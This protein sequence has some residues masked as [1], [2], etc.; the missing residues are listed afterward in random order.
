L[1]ILGVDMEPDNIRITMVPTRLGR[2]R[3][4]VSGTGHPTVLWHSLFVD[5]TSW[6]RVREPLQASRRL[7]IIDGPSHGDSEPVA[8]AF[9]LEGCA[10]AAIDVLNHFEVSLPVDWVGN[11]WGGHVGI[12]FAAT[13]PERC[14]SLIT[15]GTPVHALG[16]GERRKIGALV[17]LYRRIGPVRPLVKMVQ[18]GLLSPKTC[19][20]DADVMGLVCKAFRRANRRGMRTAMR[21]V[22]LARQDLTSALLRITAPTLMV[23]GSELATWTLADARALA[24]TM[25]RGSAAV[26]AGARHLAP[27]EDASA[28]VE[29]VTDFWRS[30]ETQQGSAGTGHEIDAAGAL[31]AQ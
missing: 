26:V 6:D 10:G 17:A 24:S 5:S 11:A 8:R 15:I 29:V 25:P 21:S 20:S 14:R 16:T 4:E 27:L 31:A 22:M 28:V 1:K 30:V 7:L 2:L 9:T 23:T 13:Y 3:V 18:G 19:A 12:L